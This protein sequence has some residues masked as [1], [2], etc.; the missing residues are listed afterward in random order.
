METDIQIKWA[1]I[2]S[3]SNQFDQFKMSYTTDV[4]E[5]TDELV[6]RGYNIPGTS[7]K[8]TLQ[9]ADGGEISFYRDYV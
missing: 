6:S 9:H 5:I 3:M 7:V 1:V 8:I 4:N 2:T